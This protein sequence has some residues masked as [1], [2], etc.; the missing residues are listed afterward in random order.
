MTKSEPLLD[1]LSSD[2]AVACSRTLQS[3]APSA[4][5][6]LGSALCVIVNS[7]VGHI[8]IS[9]PAL[10]QGRYFVQWLIGFVGLLLRS[11]L[12]NVDFRPFGPPGQRIWLILR[13]C[14]YY[15][16]IWLWWT[17]LT[18]VPVGDAVAVVKSEVFVTGIM[19]SILFRER[20][21][22]RW[23]LCCCASIVGVIMVV[24]P[25]ALF[26]GDDSANSYGRVLNILTPLVAGIMP[27]LIKLSPDAHF[28]EVQHTCDF[29]CA[30]VFSPPMML[31]VSESY[32]SLFQA[33]TLSA[34]VGIAI[35]GMAALCSFTLAYQQGQ[36]GRIAL[37]GYSEVPISYLTQV[38]VFGTTLELVPLAGAVLIV[39]SAAMSSMERQTGNRVPPLPPPSPT[40]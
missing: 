4:L 17:T 14:L 15:T 12:R 26:G 22:Y 5:M 38:F 7:L 23:W 21:T 1:E 2:N 29:F 11:R 19:S 30:L 16:F 10:I 25:P 39:L 27:C 13:A 28:L 3:V 18:L 32:G 36:A 20:L 24:R 9:L 35:L 33:R 31:L 6:L 8:S 40:L 37:I 34:I